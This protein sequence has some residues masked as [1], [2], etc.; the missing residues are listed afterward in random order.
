M[1][2]ADISVN[3]RS[4]HLCSPKETKIDLLK[5]CF[6]EPLGHPE[7]QD[8]AP[9]TTRTIQLDDNDARQCAH[10]EAIIEND[11][12]IQKMAVRGHDKE[13]RPIIVKFCREA[14]WSVES[15]HADEGFTMSQLYVA[16]RAIAVAELSSLGTNEKLTAIFDFGAYD[17]SHAPP[18]TVMV[19]TLK[20][21]QANYP[22]RLGK[23]LILDTPYWMQA[24]MQLVSPFLSAATRDKL[25]LLGSSILPRLWS[26]GPSAEEVRL[27]AVRAIVD[28]DQAMPFMLP[29]A[30]RTSDID[31]THQLRRVPF[32]ELYDSIPVVMEST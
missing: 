4:L 30:S 19:E 8:A 21:L 16:E 32:F 23:A 2:A 25:T 28:P 11:L 5:I 7:T 31:V 22:E 14:K 10:F 3:K 1:P 15:P 29:D 12:G 26:S 13:N 27:S 20:A 9:Q 18:I 6:S 24:V 17:S